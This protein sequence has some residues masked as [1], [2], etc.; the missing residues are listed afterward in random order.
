MKL[1]IVANFENCNTFSAYYFSSVRSYKAA[2]RGGNNNKQ[3]PPGKGK[4]QEN[5]KTFYIRLF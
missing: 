5:L 1:T 2:L 3:T 4:L